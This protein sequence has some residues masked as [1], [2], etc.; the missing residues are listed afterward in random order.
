MAGERG[1]PILKRVDR[2]AGIP[3]VVSLG[4]ARSLLRLRS[5]AAPTLRGAKVGV[6]APAA[7][8]DTVL[9]TGMIRNLTAAGAEVT[10]ITSDS[11]AAVAPLIPHVSRRLS[12]PV[13]R[14]HRALWALRKERF[15]VLVDITPWPRLNALLSALSG[16]KFTVGFST[17]GQY[18]HYAYD[19]AVAHSH[20]VH[21][22]R[23]CAALLSPFGIRSESQ[24]HIDAPDRSTLPPLAEHYVVFHAWPGGFKS[25][26]REWPLAAWRE[27]ASE[28]ARK[29]LPI[30]LTGGKGDSERSA[31]L[32]R[33]LQSVG[34]TT[35]DLAGR[36][37][38]AQTATLLASATAVVSVDTG[39][40]H[41]ASAVEA[42]IIGLHGPSSSRRWGAL[43]KRGFSLDASGR[44]AGFL[45]LGFEY[46][47]NPPHCMQRIEPR[48]VWELLAPML[49][50]KSQWV[51]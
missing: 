1:N 13:T 24:P 51:A 9:A 20:D 42:P 21:Q 41:V 7:I 38:L 35:I 16:A 26:F 12:I 34:A 31:E 23:N 33:E 47:K 40:L 8:G 14:P 4:A 36:L 25:E 6:L 30:V 5:S 37:S 29:N 45:S 27:L 11:N 39:I 10:L 49:E 3:L 17:P 50:S 15:D 22:W 32:A 18:R 2:W 44:D 19:A 46:P 28:V 48:Q 43:G